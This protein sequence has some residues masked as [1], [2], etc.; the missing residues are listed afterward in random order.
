M[1]KSKHWLYFRW[2]GFKARSDAYAKSGKHSDYLGEYRD[3]EK[4]VQLVESLP[5]CPKD[6]EKKLSILLKNN[7]IGFRKG[8]VYWGTNYPT[9]KKRNNTYT[10][11]YYRKTNKRWISTITI[12]G[13]NRYLGSYKT[14]L[15]A[16]RERNDFIQRNNMDIPIQ[17]IA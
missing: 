9:G 4:F 1:I 13:D 7:S 6:T 17:L 3:F 15:E 14:E 2:K 8:N 10:G 11:I 16:L 5:N 12:D